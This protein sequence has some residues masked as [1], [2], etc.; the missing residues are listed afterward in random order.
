LACEWEFRGRRREHT[1]LLTAIGAELLVIDGSSL[2]TI[3][4][5]PRAYDID[6]IDLLTVSPSGTHLAVARRFE[7]R[8]LRIE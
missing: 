8:I 2:A 1:R 6:R 7:V 5:L 3:G 4:S